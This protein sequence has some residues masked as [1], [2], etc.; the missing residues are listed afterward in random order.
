M[1]R[2]LMDDVLFSCRELTRKQTEREEKRK[3]CTR[4]REHRRRVK[5]FV[6]GTAGNQNVTVANT[7]PDY[8]PTYPK[9]SPPLSSCLYPCSPT[10]PA[11]PSLSLCWKESLLSPPHCLPS[12]SLSLP[13]PLSHLLQ[14]P[15]PH[16]AIIACA[17]QLAWVRGSEVDGPHSA[18]V[19]P[20]VGDA[21]AATHVPHLRG[22]EE[23]GR[24]G[25]GEG[26]REGA[27]GG[28]IVKGGERAE[29][30]WLECGWQED[31][32]CSVDS[33]RRSPEDASIHNSK[34]MCRSSLLT[35]PGAC[36]PQ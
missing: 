28:S 15:Q 16:A 25:R 33:V 21:P 22:G 26:G 10:L 23:G 35:G 9:P 2:A 18:V 7:P 11:F 20:P 14:A 34:A 6:A 27:Q 24:E 4:V 29:I 8:F 19:L 13:L 12:P 5:A 3:E 17:R 32:D 36:L 1:V 30:R 31:E